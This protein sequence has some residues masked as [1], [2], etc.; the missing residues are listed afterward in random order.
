LTSLPPSDNLQA[1]PLLNSQ[2]RAG[3]S[4]TNGREIY[5]R[6][7]SSVSAVRFDGSGSE[8]VIGKPRPL[9]RD[10]YDLGLGI[11]IANYDVTPDG[12]FLMLR[13]DAQGGHLRIVL[14]WTEDLK[15]ALAQGAKP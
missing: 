4:R 13:R 12:K 6:G 15:R 10:E 5:H 2:Q 8:P 9:F 14:N 1:P 7:A 11:T 3:H